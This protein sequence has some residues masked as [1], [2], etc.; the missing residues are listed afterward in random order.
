MLHV[1]PT[2]E[3]AIRLYTKHDFIKVGL[4]ENY[5]GLDHARIVMCVGF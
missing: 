4:E 3:A 1:A 5:F 2:N